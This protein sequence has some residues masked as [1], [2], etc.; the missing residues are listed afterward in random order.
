MKVLVL[1][2]APEGDPERQAELDLSDAVGAVAAALPSAELVAIRDPAD[3]L[4]ALAR[5]QP[6]VVWN[7]AE[8]PRGDPS[9]EA[10]V[11]ALLEWSGVRF[12]GAG[13]AALALC[14]R[15]DQVHAVL[16]EA[17]VRVPPLGGLPCVVKPRDEDGS[18]GIDAAS[19]CHTAAERAAATAR[20]GERAHVERYLPGQELAVACWSGAAAVGEVLFAEDLHLLT[21]ASKWDPHSADY[22]RSPT[23][24]PA[25]IDPALRAE[26]IVLAR[27]AGAAAGLRG[28]YRA[29][30]RLDE[31]GNAYVIDLNPNPDISPG[32]GL[33]R[34]VLAAGWTWERFVHAQLQEAL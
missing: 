25:Q 1:Y 9:L 10:H 26:V 2:T 15:K 7:A 23:R 13:S 4:A 6:D 24:Y 17:G 12:T 34:A 3:V 31:A 14:R 27:Q 32:G 29:D 21:Y 5:V 22:Q 19:L 16:A 18:V 11:A 30:V 33:Q 20:L 8:A 28:A